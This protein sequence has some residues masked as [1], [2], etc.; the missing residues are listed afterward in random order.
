MAA[1]ISASI[2]KAVEIFLRDLS[3]KLTV[4]LSD[5][6]DRFNGLIRLTKTVLILS[7][8]VCSNLHDSQH[9]T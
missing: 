9:A 8:S 4:V 7:R 6:V 2:S 3:K 5:F 1:E